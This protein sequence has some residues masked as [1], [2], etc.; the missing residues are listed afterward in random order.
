MALILLIH[1][2]LILLTIIILILLL[3]KKIFQDFL[4]FLSPLFDSRY[5]EREIMSIE[6]KFKYLYGI[7]ETAMI[8]V[9]NELI[10][11]RSISHKIH[12]WKF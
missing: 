4:N 2:T 5:A 9:I 11:K 8:Q 3:L 1:Q 6:N 7:L 10:D 12:M